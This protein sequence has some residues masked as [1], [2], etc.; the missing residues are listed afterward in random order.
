MGL[1]LAGLVW[2]RNGAGAALFGRTCLVEAELALLSYSDYEEVEAAGEFVEGC[3]VGGDFFGRD[4]P[5]RDMNIFLEDIDFVDQGLVESAVAALVLVCAEW[6][7][8]V[9]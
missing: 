6:I 9:D 5:V 4:S 1:T 8:L 7:I 2:E 3:A